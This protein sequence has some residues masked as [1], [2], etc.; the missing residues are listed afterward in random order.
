M[1]DKLPNKVSELI[2]VAANDLVK[3]HENK[4]YEIDMRVYHSPKIG[5]DNVCVVCLAGAVI[6]S[7]FEVDSKEHTCPDDLYFD[8]EISENDLYKLDFLDSLRSKIGI[9]DLEWLSLKSQEAVEKIIQKDDYQPYHYH[10][11]PYIW[12]DEMTK[13]S[14]SL[15]EQGH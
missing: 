8:D 3:C 12:R 14:K 1:K 15:S 13:L 7:T 5:N 9:Y 4:A 6:A 10:K 11:S 2:M